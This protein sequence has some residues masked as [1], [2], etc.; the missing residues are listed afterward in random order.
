[1]RQIL[2]ILALVLLLTPATARAQAFQPNEAGVT[3]GHWHLNTRDLD[4]HRKILVAMGGTAVKAGDFE[5]VQFPGVTVYLHGR[6]RTAPTGGTVGSVVDHVGFIVPNVA[7]AVARWKAA[8]V[9]VLPGLNGRTDQAYVV[10]PDELRIEI[11]EDKA[12]TFPIRSHHVH[13]YGSA[14]IKEIQAWY[15]DVFGARIGM[16]GRFQSVDVPG[17][18]ISLS[19]SEKPLP[20]T[21]GRVLDHI[22]FDVVDLQAF[23][24]KIEGKG[25]K[26]DRPFEPRPGGGLAFIYDPWGTYIELNQRPD[27]QYIAN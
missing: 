10:T 1:M 14:S 15:A 11:L 19:E 7:E 3:N 18:N 26:L 12:Q 4:A 9:A 24:K 21:R 27:P 22:G 8:G 17:I 6:Q 5:L 13:L 25:V 23:L 16:R 20:S 2:T